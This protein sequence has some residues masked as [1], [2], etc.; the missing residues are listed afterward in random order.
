MLAVYWNWMAALACLAV[1][2][3]LLLRLELRDAAGT[4]WPYRLAC[5]LPAITTIEYIMGAIVIITTL[6]AGYQAFGTAAGDAFTNLGSW[7]TSSMST[8][9]GGN[10]PPATVTPVTSSN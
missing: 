5:P 3:A 9:T 7:V 8:V 2:T 6:Y 4:P 1:S 10:T